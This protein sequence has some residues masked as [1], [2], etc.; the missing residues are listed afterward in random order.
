M[1]K[2]HRKIIAIVLLGH[3]MAYT[4]FAPIAAAGYWGE[5]W[6]SLSYKQQLEEMAQQVRDAINAAAKM[7]SIKMVI[8]MIEKL[9]YGNS[10]SPRNIRNFNDFLIADPLGAA[11][12]YGQDFLTQTMRGM[13]SGDYTSASGGVGGDFLAQVLQ[14]AGQSVLDEWS[15][16]VTQT[17]D[18]MDYCNLSGGSGV[19]GANYLTGQG[20]DGGIFADGNFLCFSAIMANPIN[21]PVGMALAVDRATGAK[22]QQEQEVAKL[23]ATSTGVL[24]SIDLNGMITVPADMVAYIQR[25]QAEVP[26]AALAAGDSKVFSTLIQSFAVTMIVGIM[27]R[28]LGE[29]SEAIDKNI[30]SFRRQYQEKFGDVMNTIGPAASYAS[31]AYA[32]AQKQRSNS[33][34]W[35]NP[36]TPQDES[37]GVPWDN[38]DTPEDESKQGTTAVPWDNPDTP[39][40]ESKQTTTPD[41]QW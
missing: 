33:A 6:G 19:G 27:Q 1:H 30:A 4:T 35:D 32:A 15:G 34:P 25:A 10:S 21:T 13:G 39:I 38:P 31:D 36:D 9:L 8:S 26:L 23:M 18:Y 28:G 2:T 11:V 7:A 5:T 3:F 40:D 14:D 29:V 20:G 22:Y 17:V 37:K 24:P 41:R 12:T 16:K